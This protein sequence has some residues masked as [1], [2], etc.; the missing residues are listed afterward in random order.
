MLPDL[1]ATQVV[2]A[3]K[4][5]GYDCTT[6]VAYAVC[7]KGITSIGVLTGTH[8][9]PPVLSVQASGQ[10][11]VAWGEISNSLPRILELAHV[12]QPEIAGWFDQQKG[13]PIAQ[14]AFGD[15]L[16][17]ISAEVDTEEPGVHLTLT[18]K[19]CKTNCQAE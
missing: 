6:D 15:W 12:N 7:R 11:D 9:R 17:D 16:V 2:S 5:D 19:L 1:T 14:Q 13:K 18:D 4:T 8:P 10:V 3:L